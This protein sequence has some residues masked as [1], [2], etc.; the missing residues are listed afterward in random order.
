MRPL[1]VLKF[2]V[3]PVL[4]TQEQSKV[5]LAQL[6]VVYAFENQRI[7]VAVLVVQVTVVGGA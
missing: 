6:K 1:A 4:A 7:D 2:L 5:S 3:I